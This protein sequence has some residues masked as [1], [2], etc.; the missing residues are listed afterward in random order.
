M[1]ET[2]NA[3]SILPKA[4]A[5]AETLSIYTADEN[6]VA[7]LQEVN[8]THNKLSRAYP[9][10]F[11]A[12]DAICTDN[13]IKP[14]GTPAIEQNGMFSTFTI[15][16]KGLLVYAMDN[17]KGRE[18]YFQ[19]Q[20]TELFVNGAEPIIIPIEI[21][22]KKYIYR[23]RPI[24]IKEILQE[25]NT[26]LT[27]EQ[28]KK[29]GGINSF[30]IK[31]ITI[32]FFTP[33][34]ESALNPSLG[35]YSPWVRGFTAK[36]YEVI[37]LSRKAKWY[38]DNFYYKQYGA[39][40]I[41]YRSF[42]L[43]FLLHDNGKAKSYE[44]DAINFVAEVFPDRVSKKEGKLYLKCSYYEIY[45]LMKKAC[46]LMKDMSDKGYLETLKCIPYDCY[47]NKNTNTNKAPT[48]TFYIQRQKPF[49]S[50]LPDPQ[51][52]SEQ[53]RTAL[54]NK[55]KKYIESSVQKGNTKNLLKTNEG[56]TIKPVG[57]NAF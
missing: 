49:G 33:L 37:E 41:D 18:A 35:N 28:I 26:T 42:I 38:N 25:N 57:R 29:Y 21:E 3:Y 20:I 45:T 46:H 19:K 43:V 30:P 15:L 47:W 16:Y 56:Y 36:M 4:Q 32:E 52:M 6:T 44:L 1:G 22:G 17:I 54:S 10:L 40:P 8:S 31:S 2:M 55:N 39:T 53:D 24:V 5:K 13:P 11:D 51:E 48:I 7:A 12:L 34:F 9:Y 27:P 50:N 23:N 14:D